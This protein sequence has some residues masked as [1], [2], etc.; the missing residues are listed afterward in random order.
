MINLHKIVLYDETNTIIDVVD[1]LKDVV[2]EGSDATWEGGCLRGIRCSFIVLDQSVEIDEIG[3]TLP[4]EVLS[5][6]HKTSLKTKEKQLEEQNTILQ[7]TIN[8]LLGI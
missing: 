4:D 3:A 1:S 5:Q 7:D 6:D 8:Y 2:V